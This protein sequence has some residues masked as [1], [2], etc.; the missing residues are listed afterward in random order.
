MEPVPRPE[1]ASPIQVGVHVRS[2]YSALPEEPTREVLQALRD[3]SRLL[4]FLE[5]HPL[6]RLEFS[7]R[8]PGPGWLGFYDPTTGDLTVNAFRAPDTFGLEFRPQG[9]ESVSLAGGDLVQAMK[10]TLYH[11]LGHHILKEA[12]PEEIRQI[13]NLRRSGRAFPISKRARDGAWEYFAETYSAYRF[14]DS[15]ADKDPDGYHMV[16]YM[17]GLLWNR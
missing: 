11:E 2:F 12:G 4:S 16:E 17:L 10:R 3:D 8:L 1:W 6:G 7:A 13:E 9:L 5:R 15:L 14:E